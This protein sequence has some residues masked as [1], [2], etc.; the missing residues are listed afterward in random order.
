MRTLILWLLAVVIWVG[1]I[2]WAIALFLDH[3][4]DWSFGDVFWRLIGGIIIVI[5][6]QVLFVI[7]AALGSRD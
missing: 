7:I 5:V 3:H 1:G 6:S 4:G 2:A